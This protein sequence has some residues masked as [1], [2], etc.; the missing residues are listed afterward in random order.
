M[1]GLYI[2]LG[3][4]PFALG[5]LLNWYML[6]HQGAFLLWSLGSVLFLL[7]WGGEENHAVSESDPPDRSAAGGCPGTDSGRLLG[8]LHRYLVPAFL[9]SSDGL[10]LHLYR[11]EFQRFPRLCDLLPAH[12]WHLLCG[13]I[14]AGTVEKIKFDRPPFTGGLFFHR[15][16]KTKRIFL[17]TY[18]ENTCIIGKGVVM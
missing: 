12:G 9:P 2:A 15:S 4:L 3:A 14:P 16:R 13:R 10:G 5:G 17:P 1:I 6:T 8:Q 18:R 11:L 7:I